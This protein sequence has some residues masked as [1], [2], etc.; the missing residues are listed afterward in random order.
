MLTVLAICVAGVII[1]S[2]DFRTTGIAASA[3]H[4]ASNGW[5]QLGALALVVAALLWSAVRLEGATVRPLGGDFVLEGDVARE[6]R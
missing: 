3:Q 6:T 4:L 5:V 1:A 2:S